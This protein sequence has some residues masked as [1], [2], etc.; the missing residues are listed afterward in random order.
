M[1]NNG[2]LTKRQGEKR[3]FNK[4]TRSSGGKS[5][6]PYN[7]KVPCGIKSHQDER[8]YY[9]GTCI[10]QRRTGMTHSCLTG[11]VTDQDED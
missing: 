6:V 11:S 7:C 3:F 5:Y 8:K 1:E 9:E 4:E 2:H 10:L